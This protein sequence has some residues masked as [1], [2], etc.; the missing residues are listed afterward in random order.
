MALLRDRDLSSAFDDG[1]AFYDRFV[2]LN[3]GYHSQLRRSAGRLGLPRNSSRLR[4]LDLGCG[5]GASTAALLH[6]A[7]D[8]HIT[9]VDASEGMLRRA[10]AKEWPG[11]V[12]F[13]HATAEELPAEVTG[14]G[15]DAV[16]AAYLF[17]NVPDPDAV[18]ATTRELLVPGGRLAVHE[19]TL[20]GAPAH[21]KLWDAVCWGGVIPLGALRGDGPLYR[22]LWRSVVDFDTAG[23]FR[24][25]MRAAGF[26][27]VRVLPTTGWQ[28]GIVHT[29]VGAA[30]PARHGGDNPATPAHTTQEPA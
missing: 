12:K 8:A 13:V 29:A 26:Q 17:R 6:H 23:A 3:P 11:R 7:P 19:Y 1:A 27:Q 28:W 25:R 21:R 16:F 24:D 30:P 22:H 9:A 14:T 18:L 20:S 4:I 5:T 2:A 10:R 15:Y